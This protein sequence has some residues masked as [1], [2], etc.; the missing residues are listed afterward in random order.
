MD[1]HV[2]LEKLQI[3]STQWGRDGDQAEQGWMTYSIEQGRASRHYEIVDCGLALVTEAPEGMR[4]DFL[5]FWKEENFLRKL[6]F[7]GTRDGASLS[8]QRG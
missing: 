5:R 8:V 7:L 1:T 6:A 3:T 4:T 2:K